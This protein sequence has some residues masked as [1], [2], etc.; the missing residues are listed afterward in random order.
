MNTVSLSIAHMNG[1]AIKIIGPGALYDSSVPGSQ[2]MVRKDSTISSGR[3]LN[4]KTVAVNVL[5]GSAQLSSQAWIDKHGGDSRTVQWAEMPFSVMPTALDAKRVDAAAIAEP[6]ASAARATCRSLGPP[7]A[8]IADRYLVGQYVASEAWIAAHPDAA[9]RMR[10]ALRAAAHWYNGHRPETVQ[11]VATLTK[12]DPAVVERSV[13]SLF[14]ETSDPALIQPV[15]E[16]AARYGIL[17][18][19]FPASE[20]LANIP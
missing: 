4:G 13:R 16:V 1:V 18:R 7:N 6:A 9:R 17:K 2:L 12:Q 3:D 8:A 10:A 5:R 19:S 20:L 14:G 15:I 11:F